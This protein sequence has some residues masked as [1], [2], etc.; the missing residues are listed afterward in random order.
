MPSQRCQATRPP[1]R[2][3]LDHCTSPFPILGNGCACAGK[4]GE[5]LRAAHC[6]GKQ[7]LSE[8]SRD[9]YLAGLPQAAMLI[10]VSLFAALGGFLYG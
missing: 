6:G 4:K 8:S 2:I 9:D 10:R 3:T 1:G 5:S 7:R